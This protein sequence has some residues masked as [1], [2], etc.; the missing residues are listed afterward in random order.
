MWTSNGGE[1]GIVSTIV[2]GLIQ[3]VVFALIPLAVYLVTARRQGRFLEYIG[4]KR[5]PG[6]AIVYGVLVGLV[7]F[8]VMFGLTSLSGAAE[9]LSDPSSQTGRLR[10]LVASDGVPTMLFVALVQ[11]LVTTALSEEILFRGFLAKRLIGWLGFGVGNTAQA[12]VF[13]AI[14]GLLFMGAS[15]GLSTLAL[16]AVVLLPAVQGWLIG[17]LNERL[18]GGSIVPGWCAHAVANALTFAVIP[19]VL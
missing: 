15:T 17:W 7:S 9:L 8:P 19:L 10:E 3:V 6:Q 11:A 4:L 1:P 14:H 18:G 16:A 12:L 5:A 2:S 13:G